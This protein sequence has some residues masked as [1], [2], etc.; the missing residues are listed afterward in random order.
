[1]FNSRFNNISFKFV[2]YYAVE[3]IK[4]T[5]KYLYETLYNKEQEN[6]E[7]IENMLKGEDNKYQVTLSTKEKI[8][9]IKNN[10][11][12]TEIDKKPR[13]VSRFV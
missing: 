5:E 4:K 6:K 9:A 10:F 12:K 2:P 3:R 8:E 11:I 7:K 13:K 1:M